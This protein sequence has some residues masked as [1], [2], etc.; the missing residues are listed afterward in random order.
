MENHARVD[1][2]MEKKWWKL[3]QAMGRT[4]A[5]SSQQCMG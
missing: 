3:S 2:E 1:Y 4:I 5:Q